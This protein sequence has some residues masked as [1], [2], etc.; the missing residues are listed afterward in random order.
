VCGGRNFDKPL[1]LSRILDTYKEAT[2]VIHGAYKGADTLAHDWALANG[3]QAVAC[4]AAW[5]YYDKVAGYK[6]NAAML[7]LLTDKDI[8][9]AFP[10]GPG[11]AMMCKL[12]RE[13]GI[14]VD[15]YKE[16]ESSE[17]GA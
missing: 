17:T 7:E 15:E 4:P 14:R 10:G 8:V 13:K 9:V 5:N 12:A 2:H 6:R 11:T 1:W 3:I 16:E